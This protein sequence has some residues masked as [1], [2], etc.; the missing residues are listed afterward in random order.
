MDEW[1]E[2]FIGEVGATAALAGLLVVAMSIN[3]ERIM[4][5]PALTGRAAQ[6]VFLIGGALTVSSFAL[7]PVM[8]GSAFGAISVATGAIMCA[9]AVLHI[10]ARFRERSASTPLWTLFLS[11]VLVL[12]SAVPMIVGGALLA[13]G[14]DTGLIWIA[15]GVILSMIATL[16]NGWV[17]LVEILR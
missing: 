8:T 10:P 14:G 7:F 13:S 4:A 17:L 11:L 6:T 1:S 16:A 9:P 3:L 12:T 5:V 15:T 2:F